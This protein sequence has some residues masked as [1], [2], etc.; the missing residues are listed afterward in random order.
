M[1]TISL[2]EVTAS[3]AVAEVVREACDSPDALPELEGEA[4]RTGKVPASFAASEAWR[5]FADSVLAVWSARDHVIIRGLPAMGDGASLLLAALALEGRFKTYRGGKM[6]KTF[7]MSPWTKDLS[8]TLREGEFH[9]D[10]NTDSEPPAVTGIQCLD[11]DPG[12]PRYGINRVA[13]T[14]DLLSYQDP[15]GTD[16]LLRFL[17]ESRV[18]MVNDRSDSVWSGTIVEGERIRFHP[19]TLRAASQRLQQDDSE[20]EARLL[21]LHHAAL[22]VSDPFWLD[23]GDVLLVSNHRALH[24]RGECSVVFIN[25][26]LEFLS[27]SIH[28][29]HKVDE[30]R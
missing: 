21:A 23:A 14:V 10:L 19:E 17:C 30:P 11:P 7:R 20:T 1:T 9:T 26:P 24:Y 2:P 25:Y 3:T 12:A 16:Q 5:S 22:A 27:R 4:R 18:T 13:R 15:C 28:V 29:L 6:V 8:H